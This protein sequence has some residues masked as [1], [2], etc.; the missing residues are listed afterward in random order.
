MIV[1]RGDGK[2]DVVTEVKGTHS[3]KCLARAI[4]VQKREGLDD[5]IEENVNL[6]RSF[7]KR[8]EEVASKELHLTP[9]KV[10][11]TVRDEFLE[12]NKKKTLSLPCTT[13]VSVFVT[14]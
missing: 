7:K 13:K 3:A 11:A 6:E 10:Y 8:V 9:A 2:K 5:V 4:S 12:K 14:Q 1:T